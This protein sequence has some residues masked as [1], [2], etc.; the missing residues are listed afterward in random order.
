MCYLGRLLVFV[1]VLVFFKVLVFV[2]LLVVVKA[3]NAELL[4]GLSA[5]GAELFSAHLALGDVVD[6][7]STD[8]AYRHIY[9][10][11]YTLNRH[12]AE[13]QVTINAFL[14]LNTKKSFILEALFIFFM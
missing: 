1:P 7:L 2:V 8:C 5:V 6:F 3:V 12:I 4:V 14:K 9:I 10:T 11:P 13:K